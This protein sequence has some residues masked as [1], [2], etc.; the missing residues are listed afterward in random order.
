MLLSLFFL[1]QKK[2][3][4]QVAGFPKNRDCRNLFALMQAYDGVSQ[5]KSF[6]SDPLSSITLCHVVMKCTELSDVLI[7]NY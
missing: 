3:E 7:M 5:V 4:G 6:A 2:W 1:K